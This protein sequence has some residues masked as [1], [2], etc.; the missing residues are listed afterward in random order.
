MT[1]PE[2]APVPPPAPVPQV[3]LSGTTLYSSSLATP[4]TGF[5]A[6]SLVAF[7]IV[8]LA[9]VAPVIVAAPTLGI[10]LYCAATGFD[11]NSSDA[12]R[13]VSILAIVVGV[14]ASAILIGA[15]ADMNDTMSNL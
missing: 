14:L 1:T 3:T 10:G 11:E 12:N 8:G 7:V 2:A 5:S 6:R 15:L 13:L 9:L 4:D